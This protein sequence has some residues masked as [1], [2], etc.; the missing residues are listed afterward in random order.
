MHKGNGIN[1]NE[2]KTPKN[3]TALRGREETEK[4]FT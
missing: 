4:I 2:A 1:A 3:K